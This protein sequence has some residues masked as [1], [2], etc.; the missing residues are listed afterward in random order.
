VAE[1]LLVVQEAF[2]TRAGVQCMP[3]ITVISA[4]PRGSFPIEL[5]LP[6]GTKRAAKAVLETSHIRG[7]GGSFGM[8]TIEGLAVEDVPPGTEIW[9]A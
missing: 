1:R 9:S 7:P 4:P 8:Y 6:D 3:K 2:K 5:R